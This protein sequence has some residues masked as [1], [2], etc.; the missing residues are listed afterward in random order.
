MENEQNKNKLKQR[1]V[2]TGTVVSD[3]MQKTIVVRVERT[4]IHPKYQKRFKAHKNYKAHD[5]QG[6]YKI[7]DKVNFVECRPMSRGKRWRVIDSREPRN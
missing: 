2:F 7:G 1:R 5:E 4:K 6:Q 3:K